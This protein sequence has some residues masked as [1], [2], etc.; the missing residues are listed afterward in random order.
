MAG[1][2]WRS[3]KNQVFFAALLTLERHGNDTIWF[4]HVEKNTRRLEQLLGS[5]DSLKTDDDLLKLFKAFQIDPF[6]ENE[7]PP[8]LLERKEGEDDGSTYCRHGSCV[9]YRFYREA[10][11]ERDSRKVS[12]R[13]FKSPAEF[14]RSLSRTSK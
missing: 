5:D 11:R 2:Q 14:M 1:K 13:F 8:S 10:G 7:V 3:A 4:A 12:M 9:I 6:D